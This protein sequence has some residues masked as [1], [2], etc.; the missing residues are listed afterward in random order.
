MSA[1]KRH[2]RILELL[3]TEGRLMVS[4]LANRLEVSEMTIRR[5]FEVLEQTGVLSRVHG[6]AVPSDS[7]SYEPPFAVRIGRNIEAKQR[8]GQLA[9]GLLRDGETVILDAGTT[10][11][12][13]ARALR[14]RKN[15]RI[16]AL[17]LHIADVLVD[18]TGIT[19]MLSGGVARPGERSFIGTLA[20]QTFRELSFDTLFLTV[21]GI[22]PQSGLTEYNLDDAG[23]KR[24]ACASARRRIAV[25]DGSKIGK[26]AF[27]KI[28]AID[29]L[30]IL[31][32]DSTAP[33][34]VLNHFRQAGVEVIVA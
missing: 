19:T 1:H 14:G 3:E 27:V 22:D 30:D 24:A 28:C 9:A 23:I 17:S 13:I 6:G 15:L 12:E 25:A 4:D 16:L 31:I 7:R 26:T 10:T 18:E 29:D 32:T 5:D 34:D 11:L 2:A 21:G 33:D 8:I 20:E